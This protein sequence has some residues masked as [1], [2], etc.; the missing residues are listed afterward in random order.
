MRKTRF[1]LAAALATTALAAGAGS[2]QAADSLVAG[3]VGSELS[4]AVGTPSAMTLTHASAGS[5]SSVVTVTSTQPSWTLSIADKETTAGGTPGRMD[6]CIAG[7]PT[8]SDAATAG[9]QPVYSLLNAL[10]WRVTGGSFAPLSAT[11]AQV[12]LVGAL[13]GTRTVEFSQSLDSSD[14]VAAADQYCLT[15]S[16]TAS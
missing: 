10:Q 13:I 5:S 8:D 12:G 7:I 15:V 16:Y 14:A 11:P 4:L 9:L 6:K 1:T 2:A 3:T